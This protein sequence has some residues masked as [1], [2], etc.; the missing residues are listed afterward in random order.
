MDGGTLYE[1][2]LWSG[3]CF[4][5]DIILKSGLFRKNNIDLVAGSIYESSCF[6]F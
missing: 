6:N 1:F 2:Y 4:H 3:R 5:H